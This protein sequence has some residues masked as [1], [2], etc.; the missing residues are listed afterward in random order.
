M[1]VHIA[2]ESLPN[3]LA[4]VQLIRPRLPAPENPRSK[5]L[6]SIPQ[7]PVHERFRI[8]AALE[9]TPSFLQGGGSGSTYSREPAVLMGCRKW[10]WRNHVR[11]PHFLPYN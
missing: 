4:N 1:S 6:I 7:R 2:G 5:R 10:I 11:S 9:T 8:Q 3:I